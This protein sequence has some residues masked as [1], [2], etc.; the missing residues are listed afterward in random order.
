VRCSAWSWDLQSWDLLTL[1]ESPVPCSWA[2]YILG[3][4]AGTEYRALMW[5]SF[6]YDLTG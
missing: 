3:R 4:A 6:S 1:V 5:I 2:P